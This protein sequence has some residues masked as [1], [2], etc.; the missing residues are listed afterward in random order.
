[1]AN[2]GEFPEEYERAWQAYFYPGTN[3]FINKL[4]IKDYDELAKREVEIS[5]EKLVELYENPIRGEF[6]A[7]HLKDIHRYLFGEIYEWAGEFRN[8]YMKK[9]E[10]YFASEENIA[11]YLE[12]DLAILNRDVLNIKTKF[13]LAEFLAINYINIQHI[14]PFREGNSRTIREFFREFV[15]E[16]TPLLETGPMEL[17]LSKMNPEIMATARKFITRTF[18]GEIVIEFNNALKPVTLE[19]N[20]ANKK[21]N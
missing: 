21:V 19:H 7:E 2:E 18:P 6:D 11:P 9:A 13:D 3:V 5:F 14:H 1:M 15:L 17:D 16:K 10:T 8:V 20:E 12:H 4:G